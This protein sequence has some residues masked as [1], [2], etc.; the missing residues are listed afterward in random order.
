METIEGSIYAFSK[1]RKSISVKGIW[2]HNFTPLKDDIVKNKDYKIT[3][4]TKKVDDKEFNNIKSIVEIKQEKCS[5]LIIYKKEEPIKELTQVENKIRN[6]LLSS[7]KMKIAGM[8]TSYI[9]DV[10]NTH[11]EFTELKDRPSLID[12]T[13]EILSAYKYIMENL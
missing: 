2:L 3:Y 13:R 1:D 4:T 9:K 11:I 10:A 7:E 5:P 6:D 8:L 12:I